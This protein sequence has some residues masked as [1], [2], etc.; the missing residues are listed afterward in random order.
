MNRKSAKL[1]VEIQPGINENRRFKLA[2]M[3]AGGGH[4]NY[5]KYI[6]TK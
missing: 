4:I 6:C 1:T 2:C 3:Y 5:E